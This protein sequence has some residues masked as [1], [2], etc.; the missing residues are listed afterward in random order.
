MAA[1]SMVGE[2]GIG[3]DDLINLKGGM[4]AWD[5]AVVEDQP[6]VQLFNWQIAPSDMLITAMNL[7]KGALNF[8]TH[9][10]RQF[11]ERSWVAVFEDLAKAEMGHA[12]TVYHYWRQ[13]ETN[14]DEFDALFDGL[15]GQVLEGGMRLSTALEKL[16]AMKGPGCLRLIEL[17]LKIEYA[18]FDLYLTM[19]ERITANDAQQAFLAIA[20]AE[21]AHMQ[22]LSKAIGR[23]VD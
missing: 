13:I 15:S 5:G 20:Q 12:R 17:A 11:K 9:V 7:E 1:A 23:C 19:A 21:K 8:Y 22:F 18:A 14:G 4:L 2:E 6:N 16:S 10:S 3:S